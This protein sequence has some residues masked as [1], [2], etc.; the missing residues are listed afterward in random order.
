MRAE[1]EPDDRHRPVDLGAWESVEFGRGHGNLQIRWRRAHARAGPFERGDDG[2]EER[3]AG[4]RRDRGDARRVGG[5]RLVAVT[6]AVKG[7]RS[8][9]ITLTHAERAHERNAH[10]EDQQD[11]GRRAQC[12][13]QHVFQ[14]TGRVRPGAAGCGRVRPGAA[15]CDQV[16]PGAAVCDRNGAALVASNMSMTKRLWLLVMGT[17][18][19]LAVVVAADQVALWWGSAAPGEEA[20]R[21]AALAGVSPGQTVAELGAGRGEMARVM[22]R[23]VLPGGR[24]IVTELDE[25]RLADLRAV[26]S[27]E[28]W[29]HVTVQRG[30]PTGTA[31]PPACCHLLYLRH[32]F[33]HFGDPSAMAR[34]LHDSVAPGGRLVVIDFEP[35]WFL[36]LIAPVASEGGHKRAHGVTPGDLIAHLRA[37]GFTLERQDPE[38]TRGSFMVMMRR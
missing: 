10:D 24:L 8:R 13:T 15:G 36:G 2:G 33:H 32:V 35:H 29:S 26:V 4:F 34:A 22:A 21:V 14:Y 17:V 30:D 7:R 27:A 3:I 20:E 37:A 11:G 1:S 38:W 23:K 28:G 18:L 25:A 9:S 5:D 16:R 12:D 31:L 19:L 6:I